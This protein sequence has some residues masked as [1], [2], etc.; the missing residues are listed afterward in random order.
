VVTFLLLSLRNYRRGRTVRDRDRRTFANRTVSA[1]SRRRERVR[2]ACTALQGV[3]RASQGHV[4]PYSAR[5]VFTGSSRWAAGI[6]IRE[7]VAQ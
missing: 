6:D 4:G 5:K 2:A 3:S 1:D 7:L